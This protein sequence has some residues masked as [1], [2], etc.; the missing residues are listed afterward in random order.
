MALGEPADPTG[1]E[2]IVIH[3][4][5]HVHP[6]HP[7]LKSWEVACFPAMKTQPTTQLS[8]FVKSLA[9]SEWT[10]WISAIKHGLPE[11]SAN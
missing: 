6:P 11:K 4:Y 9:N 1:S 8:P 5:H 3:Q 10:L 7:K 2:V